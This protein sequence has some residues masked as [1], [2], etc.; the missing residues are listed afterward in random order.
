M[1]EQQQGAAE[2]WPEKHHFQHQ[3]LPCKG[4][5]ETQSRMSVNTGDSLRCSLNRGVPEASWDFG[6]TLC[7]LESAE[8]ACNSAH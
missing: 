6:H 2:R 5:Q 3:C 1:P 8:S 4:M 7:E